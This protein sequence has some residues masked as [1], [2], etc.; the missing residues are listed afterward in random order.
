[1]PLTEEPESSRGCKCPCIGGA[2][3][4]NEEQAG[5]S[6]ADSS[7]H[8]EVCYKQ[9]LLCNNHKTMDFLVHSTCWRKPTWIA[10]PTCM[11][12]ALWTHHPCTLFSCRLCGPWQW[13]TR[14]CMYHAG[15]LHPLNTM[16]TQ[17]L[18]KSSKDH[19]QIYNHILFKHIPI[20]LVYSTDTCMCQHG[21]WSMTRHQTLCWKSSHHPSVWSW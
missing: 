8:E 4:D 21:S 2:N 19:H 17:L 10:T 5:P 18:Q 11:V 6:Q 1:M 7:T 14:S 20:N 12:K 16:I 9:G 3:Q 13:I 15:C